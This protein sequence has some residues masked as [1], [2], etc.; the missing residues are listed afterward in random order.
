MQDVVV[1][2]H[3]RKDDVGDR[4]ED[5]EQWGPTRAMEST[6]TLAK[7]RTIQS[8]GEQANRKS[9]SEEEDALIFSLLLKLKAPQN[10]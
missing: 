1:Y 9:A 5:H 8:T 4:L 2:V 6:A 10:P 3:L 7:R